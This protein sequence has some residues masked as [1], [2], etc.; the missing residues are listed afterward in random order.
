MVWGWIERRKGWM[1]WKWV[2][3]EGVDGVGWGREKERAI[4]VGWGG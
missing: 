1:G 3:Y 4:G 2:E